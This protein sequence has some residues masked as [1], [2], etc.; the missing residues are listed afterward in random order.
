MHLHQ[1]YT[2][3]TNKHQDTNI[4][5]Y[6]VKDKGAH[7]T[8]QY[9]MLYQAE[10]P[11]GDLEELICSFELQ[12]GLASVRGKTI[13]GVEYNFFRKEIFLSKH[14]PNKSIGCQ[15]GKCCTDMYLHSK[16]KVRVKVFTL[17][18]IISTS[19]N[20]MVEIEEFDGTTLVK[21]GLLAAVD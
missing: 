8:N 18:K 4:L 15:D 13:L 1:G 2:L 6:Q 12:K 20:T 9:L 21:S 14:K 5:L 11:Q 7:L 16:V 17:L 3:Q 10:R 19:L